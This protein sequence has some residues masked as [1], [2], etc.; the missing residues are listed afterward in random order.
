MLNRIQLFCNFVSPKV[1]RLIIINFFVGV[2]WFLVELSFLFVVQGFLLSIGFLDFNNTKLPEWYPTSLTSSLALLI[3]Y[4]LVRAFV[5]GLKNMIPLTVSE[6]FAV[7]QRKNILKFNFFSNHKKP[8]NEILSAFGELTTKSGTYLQH[9]S[10]AFGFAVAV[11]MLVAMSFKLAPLEAA[12]SYALLVVVML[13]FRLLNRKVSKYGEGL[14][15]EWKRVNKV[16]IDGIRNIFLLKIYRLLGTEYNKGEDALSLYEKQFVKYMSVATLISGFP[17]FAG[18]VIVAG[19]TLFSKS[20]LQTEPAHYIAFLYLFLRAA[21]NASSLSISMS[22]IRFY[23]SVFNTLYQFFEGQDLSTQSLYKNKTHHDEKKTQPVRLLMNSV[24]FAYDSQQPL[25]ENLNLNIKPGEFLL[26]K[27]PSGAG[28][29]TIIK[30]MMGMLNPVQGQILIDE[31]GPI[32]F[33]EK[34]SSDIGY[35]GPE[36]YIVHGTVRENLLYGFNGH[37]DDSELWYALENVILKD[38][39]SKMPHQLNEVLTEE[40]QLST[41]QKQRLS[42]AR[43]LLRKPR[44][45]V[46]DEATANI[47]K[48]TEEYIVNHLNQIKNKVTIIAIS[49]RDSFDHIADQKIMVDFDNK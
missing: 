22:E 20:Y 15:T 49:H 23:K 18:M 35:V 24:S 25:I 46:L 48:M 8:T 30:L 31:L 47:D 32:D 33:I 37:C 27:G 6:V 36:P 41:G 3:A 1:V 19:V 2:F 21:T 28:K 13:P 34:R 12:L 39:I 44:L 5:N 40:T 45:L 17:L 10:N 11:L 43:A 14:V 7:E 4:G 38:V 29:S 26:L 42:V 16:L 9:V